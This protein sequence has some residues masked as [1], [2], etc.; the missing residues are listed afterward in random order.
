MRAAHPERLLHTCLEL[1]AE[2]SCQ[3]APAWS[4]RH[5]YT[6]ERV[7]YSARPTMGRFQQPLK[8]I[9][10]V[11]LGSVSQHDHGT[12]RSCVA[13]RRRRDILLDTRT[14]DHR[15]QLRLCC[16]RLARQAVSNLLFTPRS[17]GGRLSSVRLFYAVYICAERSAQ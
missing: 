7:R 5:P 15:S 9:W 16:L 6:R 4:S 13:L 17:N 2:V 12:I 14:N 11:V 3:H 8:E 10:Y 1:E